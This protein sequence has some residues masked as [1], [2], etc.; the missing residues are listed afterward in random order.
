MSLVCGVYIVFQTHQNS[1]ISQL[2]KYVTFVIT[3]VVNLNIR[4]KGCALCLYSCRILFHGVSLTNEQ[5]YIFICSDLFS[6]SV[7]GSDARHAGSGDASPRN[8]RRTHGRPHG[9]PHG[10]AH[11]WTNGRCTSPGRICPLWR[12]L[13]RHVCSPSPSTSCQ[14]SNVGLLYSHSRPGR[15]GLTTLEEHMLQVSFIKAT[16]FTAGLL[17]FS[18]F[19][20]GQDP[21][22]LSFQVF[23]NGSGNSQLRN[24]QLCLNLISLVLPT[25][26]AN[27]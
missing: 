18:H 2:S 24:L 12:R 15:H 14:R 22:I 10:W 21:D 23:L 8:A 7:W 16:F 13:C 17:S 5:I 3:D 26:S 19:K 4:K 1:C 6:V 27:Y 11:G 9:R 25:T 20:C